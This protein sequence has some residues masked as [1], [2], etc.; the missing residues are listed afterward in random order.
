[1]NKFLFFLLVSLCITVIG[2]AQNDIIRSDY[3][4][5]SG[6][7]FGMC[8]ENCYQE[9]SVNEYQVVLKI[10]DRINDDPEVF[11]KRTVAN[12]EWNQILDQIDEEAFR[13]LPEVIGC[14]D[15]ADGGA[16]WIEVQSLD[17]VKKITFEYGNPPAE[18]A[19]LAT[20]LREK[21]DDL[22]TDK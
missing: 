12:E 15:C 7:S 5:K 10:A 22:F 1:M 18:L 2:C 19:E 13:A 11:T 14:P 21:R 4:I 17:L 9:L 20:I 3:T 6:S 8:V 16:E